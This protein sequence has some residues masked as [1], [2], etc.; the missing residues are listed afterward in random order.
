[1]GDKESRFILYTAAGCSKCIQLEEQL[2][3]LEIDYE[4]SYDVKPVMEAGFLSF[5]V[6][7]DSRENVFYNYH[8]ALVKVIEGSL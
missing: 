7:Y 3:R 5:P 4:Q 2:N 8:D 6:L 1:V